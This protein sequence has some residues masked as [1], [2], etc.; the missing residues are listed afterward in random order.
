MNIASHDHSSLKHH[1][2]GQMTGLQKNNETKEM[3]IVQVEKTLA[4]VRSR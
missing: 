4:I 2:G 1:G 3:G